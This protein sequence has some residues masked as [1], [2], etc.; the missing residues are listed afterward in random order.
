M[1]ENIEVTVT[2]KENQNKKNV[3]NLLLA[4]TLSALAGLGGCLVLG[5]LLAVGFVASISGIVITLA[6]YYTFQKFY[7]TKSKWLY[8]YI[9]GVA[10]IEIFLTVLIAD[11]LVIKSF[12]YVSENIIL[13]L[14]ESISLIFST[15]ELVG[16]FIADFLLAVLFA[17]IGIGIMIFDLVQKQKRKEMIM[18]TLS[19]DTDKKDDTVYTPATVVE[20]K[21]EE[22]KED[23]SDDTEQNKDKKDEDKVDSNK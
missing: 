17:L 5:L 23:K 20:T 22:V 13:T 10:I 8:V 1:E 7:K 9:V 19:N 3:K 11:G 16:A 21:G 12:A 2:E 14:G 18:S 4:G 6:M 15:N